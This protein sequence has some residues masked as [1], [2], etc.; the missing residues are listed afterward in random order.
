VDGLV[1]LRLSSLE[2]GDVDGRLLAVLREHPCCVP[3]LHLPLQSGSDAVLRR[4]N[5]QYTAG[6]FLD[7]IRRVRTTL[8]RPAVSTDI[9]VGFPGESEADFARTLRVADQAGFCKIHAFPFSPRPGTA[10]AGWTREFV[11]PDVVRERMARL[12]ALERDLAEASRRQCV[13]RTERVIVEASDEATDAGPVPDRGA[14]HQGRTD[15]YFPVWFEADAVEPGD[16]V[17]VRIEGVVG[18]RAWGTLTKSAG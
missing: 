5:R 3:H 12:T 1:R 11:P 7:M 18:G 13:G 10:A 6:A 14:R 8:D 2:P 15:R 16:V 9:V 17:T 4:M